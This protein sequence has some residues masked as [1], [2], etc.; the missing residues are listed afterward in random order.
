LLLQPLDFLTMAQAASGLISDDDELE[1]AIAADGMELESDSDPR[2][3]NP[4]HKVK[5]WTMLLRIVTSGND[6]AVNVPKIHKDIFELL[7][8][9][10]NKFAIQTL[11]G[12][13]IESGPDFPS[14]ADYKMLFKTQETKTQFVVS[15]TVYSSKTIDAIKRTSPAL[16][17]LLR[18]NKVFLDLSVTGS[19]FDVVLGPI[20][21]IHPDHTSKK[22][23][24]TD[25]EKLFR[26]HHQWNDDLKKLMT[27][28]KDNLPFG[29]DFLPPFQL[30]TRRI[31]REIDGDEFSAKTTVF[32]CASEH[33]ALYEYLLV[34]GMSEGWF[35]P[36]GRFYLLLREDKSAALKSAICYHNRML[37]SMKAVVVT[38]ISNYAMDC[39]VRP[40]HSAEERP[41]LREHIVKGGFISLIS[42][43]EPEKWIGITTDVEAAKRFVNTSVRDL[44]AE[45]YDDGTAPV[46]TTPVR[47]PRPARTDRSARTVTSR[48]SHASRT[49]LLEKQ[50][51]S[52]ADIARNPDNETHT[53]HSES[54]IARRPPRNQSFKSRVSF[55]IE[56]INL[57]D[58]QP[59][60]TA[61]DA[62]TAITAITQ[63]YLDD[64]ESRLTAR[65]QD[66]LGSR[67]SDLSSPHDIQSR[68]DALQSTISLQISQQNEQ[69]QLTMNNMHAMMCAMQQLVSDVASR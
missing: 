25:I 24:H 58:D 27:E 46:A 31:R 52:W 65:F 66:E 63:D 60:S 55:D 18:T 7:K 5:E 29:D 11:E 45:I 30:R 42:T 51:N 40:P 61:P 43:H 23:L 64:M 57:T 59:K 8:A 3:Q 17:D 26:V 15:H 49:A 16:L 34:D 68:Q 38:G 48:H 69:I 35:T 4:A 50:G 39:G 47:L 53:L 14:G 54:N 20:F 10:D 21:G 19:L 32:L 56:V 2:E 28:A 6:S 37:S 33:R 12:T 13:L 62:E 41:T 9:T 1:R 67:L 44:C 22:Q 36:V